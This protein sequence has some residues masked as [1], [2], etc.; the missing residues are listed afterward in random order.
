ML[1][2]MRFKIPEKLANKLLLRNFA[3]Y[4]P[5]FFMN[6]E[7]LRIFNIKGFY[8]RREFI[9]P[10]H[11]YWERCPLENSRLEKPQLCPCHEKEKNGINMWFRIGEFHLESGKFSNERWEKNFRWSLVD[12][13]D[14]VLNWRNPIQICRISLGKLELKST[15]KLGF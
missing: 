4:V 13:E 7:D 1:R 11:F 15:W 2:D 12:K 3:S 6:L 10:R 5:H 14:Q 8:N 9:G